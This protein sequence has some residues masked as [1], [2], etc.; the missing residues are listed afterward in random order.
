MTPYHEMSHRAQLHRE[1]NIA[2][3]ALARYRI[4]EARLT[5]LTHNFNTVYRVDSAA[6]RFVLRIQEPN[7]LDAPTIG[8]E[9]AWLAALRHDTDLAVP[10]PLPNDAGELLTALQPQGM[11]PR[12]IALFRWMDGQIVGKATTPARLFKVGML[13]AT[14]HRHAQSFI[15]PSPFTRP[16]WD[17]ARMF[18]AGSVFGSGRIDPLLADEDRPAFAEAS[19]VVRRAME[20]LGEGSEAFGLIHSD[21]HSWNYLYQRGEIKAIDFEICGWGHWILD[22]AVTI[23]A[24][25]GPRKAAM[26]DAF[27]SGYTSVRP[28]PAGFE[29]HER[30]FLL[31]RLA[32][33]TNWVIESNN[34]KMKERAARSVARLAEDIRQIIAE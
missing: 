20:E 2:E 18:G 27:L 5:L 34:P 3:A 4:R 17:W 23:E 8:S 30:A 6:G 12:H 29:Q 26:R 13:M 15:P 1:H 11:P 28:L 9:L 33:F 19:A 25:A 16:R 31:A 14:L 24:L 21:L 7:T 10:Q 32:C 22:L